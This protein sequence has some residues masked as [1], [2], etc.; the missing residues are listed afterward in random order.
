VGMKANKEEAFGFYG[1]A[2]ET[3]M[4]GDCEKVGKVLEATNDSYF[5][6]ANL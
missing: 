1:I 6:A 3:F 2:D 4:V 5:I